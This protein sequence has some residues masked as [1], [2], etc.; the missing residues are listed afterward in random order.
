[1]QKIYFKQWLNIVLLIFIASLVIFSMLS[2][3]SY[4][5]TSGKED[6]SQET[7]LVK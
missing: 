3:S 4:L 2:L 1:M 5:R 7:K 6:N